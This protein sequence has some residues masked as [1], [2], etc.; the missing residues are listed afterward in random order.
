[1]FGEVLITSCAKDQSIK[2]DRIDSLN[3]NNEKLKK[4]IYNRGI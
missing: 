2:I 1:M 3:A 4:L